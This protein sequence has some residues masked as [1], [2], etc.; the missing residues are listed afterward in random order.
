MLGFPPCAGDRNSDRYDRR[1]K[2][3]GLLRRSHFGLRGA[4]LS[5]VTVPGRI[6]TNESG[7]FGV[8]QGGRTGATVTIPMSE[9]YRGTALPP[10]R[11][12]HSR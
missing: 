10:H 11:Q 8:D 2:H 7:A 9:P 3:A 1:R 5:D 6:A 4:V 12:F